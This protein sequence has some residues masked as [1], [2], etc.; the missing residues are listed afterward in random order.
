MKPASAASASAAPSSEA[1]SP[2]SSSSVQNV[3]L[4][5]VKFLAAAALLYHAFGGESPVM[6]TTDGNTMSR[7]L[8]ALGDAV[9]N[10]MTHLMDDLAARKKLFDETPPEEV[11]YWFE[12]TGPLQVSV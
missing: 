11:K 8:Q 3:L 2:Q 10:Y 7:R 4:F 6:T 5:S 1:A 9:P 12:Y